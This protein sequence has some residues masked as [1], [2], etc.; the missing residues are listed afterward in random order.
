MPRGA[1]WLQALVMRAVVEGGECF[2]PLP[3]S[4]ITPADSIGLPLQGLESG[5][6]YAAPARP[7]GIW[8]KRRGRRRRGSSSSTPLCSETTPCSWRH[9][10]SPQERQL[11][12]EGSIISRP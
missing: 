2:V 6:L 12:R 4:D 5:H 11:T 7:A 1:S 8:R 10:T 3:P 9:G